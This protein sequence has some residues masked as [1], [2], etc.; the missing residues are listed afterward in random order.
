MCG[1]VG[2][3]NV[4]D[5]YK[6]VI[7][8]ADSLPHRGEN[9]AG[10][11]LGNDAGDLFWER[12]EFDITDLMRKMA[13][14]DFSQYNIGIVH[15]RYGTA[16][17]RRSLADTQPLGAKMSWGS[18]HFAHNGDSPYME[19]D[20]RELINQGSVFTTSSDSELIL[21]YMGLARADN[22]LT[23]IREGLKRYRGTYALVMLVKDNDGLKLIAARDPSG[24]R[25]LSL[26][27]LG[28]GYVLAS[29]NSAFET[30][31]ASYLRD[32]LPGE[33]LV[34]SEAGLVQNW[35][36]ENDKLAPLRQCIYENIYFS[37][38]TSEVFEI[39]VGD[40]REALG[41]SLAKR[42]GHLIKPSDII[43]YVP[44][45]ANFFA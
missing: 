30:V 27:T 8:M 34:I 32:I 44:D 10:L 43:T 40:F 37:L 5:P 42:F 6:V 12:N 16:G 19:E 22:S 31:E 17:N 11:A 23:A 29:E 18:V 20:R 33:I 13:R 4:P 7:S 25:P 1:V 3:F 35:I 2:A 36:H 9:G 41:A 26:G 45:S 38:P 39:P 15:V 14:R 28:E 21:H 24:N